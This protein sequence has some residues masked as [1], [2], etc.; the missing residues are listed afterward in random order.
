MQLVTADRLRNMPKLLEI[1]GRSFYYAFLAGSRKIIE[2]QRHMNKIN[3]FP[4]PDGDTGTNLASTVMNILDNAKWKSSFKET[5][6]SMASAA[7]E[8]ARGNSGIIFAQF[9]Y[10]LSKNIKNEKSINVSRFANIV[11]RALHYP[12]DAIDKPVEGTIITVI[13]DWAKYIDSAKGKFDDFFQLISNSI[14]VAQSSL[15]DTPKKLNVLKKHKVVDAGAQ[16]FVYFLEGIRDFIRDR[17]L[18]SILRHK[19]RSVELVEEQHAFEKINYRYCTEVLIEGENLKHNKIKTAIKNLGDSLVVAGS[20]KKI[21]V[22]IHTNNPPEFFYRLRNYGVLSYQK[23]EDMLRQHQTMYKRKWKIALV[24][25]SVC[26]LP[27]DVMD[28]YQIHLVPANLHFGRNNYLDK[29][30]ITPEQFYSIIDDAEEYPTSSQPA[31]KDFIK[32]Y[33]NLAQFYDS[34]IAIHMSRHVSG[35]WQASADAAR[36]VGKSS[37]KKISVLDSGTLSGSLGLIVDRAAEAIAA[38]QMHDD[39]VKRAQTWKED[40]PVFVSVKTLKYMVKGG[41][42]SPMKGVLANILNLKPIVSMNDEG[43]TVL[44]DKAFSRKGNMKKIIELVNSRLKGREV[45][46]YAILHAHDPDGA[47]W[48]IDKIKP[49]LK[50]DPN[51]LIDISPI[52]GLH[53]GHGAIAISMMLK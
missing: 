23:A 50:K 29:M 51:Y 24:T 42:V 25:D 9:I 27:P 48:F 30:T 46:K 38:G 3:V 34:V 28:K 44:Y 47:E 10:G 4:V 35:T 7:I 52:V 39:I 21:R 13:R 19:P 1:D 17:D 53:A 14:K 31:I 8:G 2:N 49:I 11:N 26:D 41:R 36:Q 33:S 40:V 12:I 45:W 18:K 15:R 20:E 16:G 43:K 5:A 22:H 6:D 37:G 32:L